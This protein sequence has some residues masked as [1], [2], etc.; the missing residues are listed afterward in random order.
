MKQKPEKQ[1]IY[2]ETRLPYVGNAIF[3]YT[4][5]EYRRIMYDDI[6][7]IDASGS[8]CVLHLADGNE[9]TVSY[10]LEHVVTHELPHTIFLRIHRSYA[11]NIFKVTKFIGNTAFIGKQML[12]ISGPNKKDFL[13]C[14]HKIYSKRGL[15]E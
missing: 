9:I 1:A 5:D 4:R 7:W 12:P 3:V 15:G 13:A 11:I 2:S 8:Y 6:L 10:P 14:F